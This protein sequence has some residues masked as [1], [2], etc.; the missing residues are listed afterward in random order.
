MVAYKSNM[1]WHLSFDKTYYQR[2]SLFANYISS[3]ELLGFSSEIYRTE[4]KCKNLRRK[5]T[6]IDS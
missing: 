6:I 1:R 2:N 3:S 4:R 5:E